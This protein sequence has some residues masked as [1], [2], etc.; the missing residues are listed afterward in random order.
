MQGGILATKS[1]KALNRNGRSRQLYRH[2][3]RLWQSLSIEGSEARTLRDVFACGSGLPARR[4]AT[5]RADGAIAPDDFRGRPAASRRWVADPNC[6]V[7]DRAGQPS[8]VRTGLI[9]R[10]WA[11]RQRGP[12]VGFDR[13]F[14]SSSV[15]AQRNDERQRQSRRTE[16]SRPNT[17][18]RSI[19]R[20]RW[21]RSLL[22]VGHGSG[23]GHTNSL[24]SSSTA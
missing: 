24:R 23:G 19:P 22:K 13:P 7:T 18:T 17:A 12:G 11:S 10:L 9:P 2:M 8:L 1:S 5:D 6:E 21:F 14:A 15:A 16:Q 20:S 4:A 3:A